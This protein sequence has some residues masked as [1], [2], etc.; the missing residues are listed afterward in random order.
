MPKIKTYK[1]AAKRFRYSAG[2]KLLR[3][4]Q[5]KG[6]LRRRSPKR[7]K[8]LFDKLQT[9]EVPSHYKRIKR[10]APTLKHD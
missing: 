4:K 10:L 5:G 3:L 6:H 7:S 1:G 8:R 9:S 2:G